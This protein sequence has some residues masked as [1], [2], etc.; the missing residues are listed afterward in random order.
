MPVYKKESVCIHLLMC[1]L[2]SEANSLWTHKYTHK[3]WHFDGHWLYVTPDYLF[4]CQSSH[5]ESPVLTS[6]L[7]VCACVLFFS[8]LSATTGMLMLHRELH[9]LTYGFCSLA[10]SRKQGQA[11]SL[12]WKP[13]DWC[14]FHHVQLSLMSPEWNWGTDEALLTGSPAPALGHFVMCQF[15]PFS[16]WVNVN[17][18]MWETLSASS[19]HAMFLNSW[20]PF[21]N[22]R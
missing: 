3:W 12:E 7:C 22:L 19:S 6:D 14:S 2:S 13:W 16:F 11:G 1:Q 9:C 21:V 18:S 15:S 20:F 5:P 10:W 4:L 17:E 8:S